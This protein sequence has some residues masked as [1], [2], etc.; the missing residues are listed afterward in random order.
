[1]NHPNYTPKAGQANHGPFLGFPLD[2]IPGDCVTSE[3]A[4]VFGRPLSLSVLTDCNS[5]TLLPGYGRTCD[6]PAGSHTINASEAYDLEV[7]L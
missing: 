6:E 2:C 4:T 5:G 1:M 7:A 3:T